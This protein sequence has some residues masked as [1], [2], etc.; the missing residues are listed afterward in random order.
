LHFLGHF[1]R[2]NFQF[3]ANNV[4]DRFRVVHVR[5][6]GHHRHDWHVISQHVFVRVNDAS[7]LGVNDLLVNVLLGRESGVFIVLDHLQIDQPKREPAEER[8]ETEADQR[9]AKTA[10]PLHRPGR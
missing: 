7:S 5:C 2:R 10:S 3:F 6:I 8:D 1:R 4:D 9:A